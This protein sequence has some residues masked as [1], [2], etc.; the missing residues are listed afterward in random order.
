MTEMVKMVTM[1]LENLK[2][3]QKKPQSYSF[4]YF[5]FFNILKT[6]K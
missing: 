2:A 6:N 5:L 3:L 4:F 1:T